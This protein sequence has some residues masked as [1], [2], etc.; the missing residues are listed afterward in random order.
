MSSCFCRE[1]CRE[2][3]SIVLGEGE[4]RAPFQR[5]KWDNSNGN[6]EVAEIVDELEGEGT[7]EVAIEG[8][9]SVPKFCFPFA[10]LAVQLTR[11]SE[12]NDVQKLM[13]VVF[14][15]SSDEKERCRHVKRVEDCERLF[16]ERAHDALSAEGLQVG[17]LRRAGKGPN[18]SAVFDEKNISKGFHGRR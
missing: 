10:K 16:T 9:Q 4:R 7:S 2:K 17:K 8:E 13:D 18:A 3:E 1:Y 11:R 5:Q 6:G 14:G 15:V 12:R